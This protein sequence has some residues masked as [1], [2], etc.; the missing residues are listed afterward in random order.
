MVFWNHLPS[1]R[2][3]RWRRHEDDSNRYLQEAILSA[4]EYHSLRSATNSRC[5]EL[6]L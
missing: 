1:D 3:N 5:V 2:P 4:V 6:G